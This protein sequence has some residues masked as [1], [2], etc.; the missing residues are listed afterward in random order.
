MTIENKKYSPK[1]FANGIVGL[2]VI[3]GICSW[4]FGGSKEDPESS[5]EQ[6][7]ATASLPAIPKEELALAVSTM[8]SYDLVMDAAVSQDG[9]ILSLA[10]I[11][12]PAIKPAF[13]REY[14]D[15]FV[16]LVGTD[17]GPSN[18]SYTVGVYRPDKTEIASGYKTPLDQKIRWQE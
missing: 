16:R 1:D 5:N 13:A 12:N 2:L 8:K 15:R 17:A 9:S 7:R 4:I 6:A 10:I 18:Y 11:V 14:G 3:I